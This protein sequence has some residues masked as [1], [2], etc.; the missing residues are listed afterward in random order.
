MMLE[1]VGEALGDG[2]GEIAAELAGEIRIVGHRGFQQVVV[3]R[4]LGVGEQHRKLGPGERLGAAAPL[5]Q[6]RV[7]GQIFDRAVE[8]AALLQR[9]DQPL[10]E[11]EILHA[12]P[13]GERQRQRLQIIVAQHER[14]DLVGHFGQQRIAPVHGE[15]A[16][17]QRNAQ[18]DL[19]IDLHVG[20]VDAGRIVDGVGI[21]PNAAQRRLDAAALGHAEIG[22][23]ADHLAAQILAGD[24]NGI[25]GAVAD[26]FVAFVGGAH[27]GADA[28]E[29]DQ[30]DLRLEDRADQV[31]RR[32]AFADAEQLLRLGRQPDLLG[33][34]RI[35]AAALGD[36]RLVEIL[37]ARARQVE[38]ALALGEGAL[39]IGIGIDENVAVIEGGDELGG[40]LA[41]HAVAEHVARHVADADHGE[42]RRGD[43]DIHLAEMALDRFPGAAR[44]DADLLVVVAGRA[45]GGEGVAEPEIVGDG[46]V[47]GDV[48]ER[49]RALVG[50]DHEI[51]IVAF[52]AHDV[53]RRHDAGRRR[54]CR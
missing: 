17:A 52:V 8:Q 12:A 6:R 43:V 33:R 35:D 22:A 9:L 16:V 23:L 49:R 4:Q 15:A 53:G 3:E 11:A 27:I 47:V 34:A 28:A 38:Q 48:G 39:R 32:Q 44:G 2:F 31:L 14:R 29:E 1:R 13:L 19:D 25:V 40:L 37:P 41:Q 30:V 42:R 24:A 7:V 46:N 36:Q 18:R 21:E 51:R 5:G 45:A 10:Q 54:Y 50:G 20:G 26:R